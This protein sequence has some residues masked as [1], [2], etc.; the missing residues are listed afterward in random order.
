MSWIIWASEEMV[1]MTLKEVEEVA[2]VSK[3]P[4]SCLR[5]AFKYFILMQFA[6]L[7]AVLVQHIPSVK[8]EYVQAYQSC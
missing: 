5:T 4:T 6:C 2:L 8:H 1:E 3:Q 7:S